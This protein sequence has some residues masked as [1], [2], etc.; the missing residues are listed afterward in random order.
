MAKKLK[1]PLDAIPAFLRISPVQ[2]KKAWEKNPPRPMAVFTELVKERSKDEVAEREKIIKEI[3]EQ[4]ER[5]QRARFSKLKERQQRLPGMI[6]NTNISRWVHP[7]QMREIMESNGNL[8]TTQL[9]EQFNEL[10]KKTGD[11]PVKRFPDRKTAERRLSALKAKAGQTNGVKLK[12]IPKVK[13]AK[14]DNRSKISKEFGARVGTNREKLIQY[15]HDNFKKQVAITDVV[16]AVYG[17][18][19][20]AL[21]AAVM[22]VAGGIPVMI[23]K[24][25]LSY[26]FKK[27]KNEEKE[28]TIG[29]YPKA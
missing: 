4:K 22:M 28:L 12:R 11:K 24:Q 23:K 25:K 17:K 1:V 15:L 16:K 10:A 18:A 7:K 27:D 3:E 6:W 13:A 2:R 5:K 14:E 20:P 19:D 29:L 9:A 26:D 8:S 21:R